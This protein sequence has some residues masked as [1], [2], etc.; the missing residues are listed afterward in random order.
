MTG[1]IDFGYR[2]A[3]IRTPIASALVPLRVLAVSAALLVVAAAAGI[4]AL[5]IGDVPL[6]LD[7][8]VAALLG[9]GTE[10]Q[11]MVVLEWRL[12]VA[13]AALIFG[14]MLGLGGA[15]FQSLTRNPLGSPDVIG[16]DAGS[17]TAVVVVMLVLGSQ[18]SWGIAAA[19]IAGG[20][21]TASA[22]YVLAYRRGIQ[23]FR[24][25]VVGIGVSALLGSLNSY[26]IT[27]ADIEDAMA[28]GFWG[29][30]SVGRVTWASLGP[31]LGIAVAIVVV[32]LLLARDLR[33]LELGD[34]AAVTQGRRPGPARLAL[35][36]IG[37]A[38]VALV[39]AAAGPIGFVALVA[40]Q[41][42][43]RLTGSAGVSLLGAACMG[44][45]L[46]SSAH[47]LTLGIAQVF[48]PVP[49]GLITVCLGGLYLIRLLVLE[50]RRQHGAAR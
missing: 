8:V 34:D 21:L 3:T 27:R 11:Q 32:A 36:V 48:R 5:M 49:V 41:L 19:A 20:L 7:E 10:L 4:A 44:A 39:T 16:F 15:I 38:T 47:L 29:A 24:L 12:P 50:A 45:L 2:A 31:S 37:V 28:V 18:S 14:A 25:I 1:A 43:R 17:Y 46:L 33:A 6:R 35:I 40:P 9:G 30:G 13:L 23:G 22:V 42:A 26:L